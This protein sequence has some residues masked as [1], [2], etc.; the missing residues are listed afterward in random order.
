MTSNHGRSGCSPNCSSLVQMSPLTSWFTSSKSAN[1]ANSDFD[2]KPMVMLLG[3]INLSCACTCYKSHDHF[4]LSL[5]LTNLRCCFYDEFMTRFQWFS[6]FYY[7]GKDQLVRFV[8]AVIRTIDKSWTLSMLFSVKSLKAWILCMP[9]R[10]EL[11]P[12]VE[13][14]EKKRD[15][16]KQSSFMTTKATN[17]VY[18][19]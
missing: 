18:S 15:F 14:P 16:P 17:F 12:T 3:Q 4:S 10:A 8:F 9:L 2:A 6:D 5:S 11:E 19:I 7:H 1:M 13:S